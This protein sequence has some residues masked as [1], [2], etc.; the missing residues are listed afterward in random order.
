MENTLLMQIFK[1]LKQT[2]NKESGLLFVKLLMFRQMI[3]EVTTLHQINDKIQVFSIFKG[4][5]HIDELWVIELTQK[6]LF[7]HYRVHTSFGNDSRLH[8][9]LHSEQLCGLF[10]FYFPY[11]TEPT[12]SDYVL[13]HEIGLACF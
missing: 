8:H 1:T 12:S 5:V 2:C 6:L 7:V 9:F 3:S 11:F 10:L 13:K 4:V